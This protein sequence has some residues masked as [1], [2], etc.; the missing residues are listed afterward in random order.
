[1]HPLWEALNDVPAYTDQAGNL[2]RELDG[3]VCIQSTRAPLITKCEIQKYLDPRSTFNIY[4]YLKVDERETN[5]AQLKIKVLG[6]L[7]VRGDFNTVVDERN[8]RYNLSKLYFNHPCQY[9][10]DD[11][12]AK[13]C[14]GFWSRRIFISYEDWN[15]ISM[16]DMLKAKDGVLLV[17]ELVYGKEEQHRVQDLINQLNYFAVVLEYQ[18]AQNTHLYYLGLKEG[19]GTSPVIIERVK[20]VDIPWAIRVRLIERAEKEKVEVKELVE[21]FRAQLD[22]FIDKVVLRAPS[23]S[24]VNFKTDLKKAIEDELSKL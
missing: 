23:E 8:W 4:S 1:M 15:T 24:F 19:V 16:A 21:E 18:D 10:H 13:R 9:V 11:V 7:I 6:P 3:M 22:D 5:A 17:A 2:V 20:M 12:Q 14:L